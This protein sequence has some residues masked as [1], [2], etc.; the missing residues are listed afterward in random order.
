M[1]SRARWIAV[2]VLVAVLL[3]TAVATAAAVPTDG[4]ERDMAASASVG[5]GF[6]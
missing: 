2:S 6:T 4:D 1:K 5:T 3:A